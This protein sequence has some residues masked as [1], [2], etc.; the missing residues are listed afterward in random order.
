MSHRKACSGIIAAAVALGLSP[1]AGAQQATLDEVLVTARKRAEDVQDVAISMSVL[2]A[3]TLADLRI[4]DLSGIGALLP[5]VVT[6]GGG[7]AASVFSI[8]GLSTTGNNPGFETGIG[9][10]IDEVYVGK[11]FAFVTPTA[12]I[13]RIEVLRGPQGTLF[14]RNTIG[15][16][17]SIVTQSPPEEF[18]AQAKLG[19]GDYERV[20][21]SASIGGP[22]GGDSTRGHLLVHYVDQ[23]GY[24]KDFISGADYMNQEALTVRGKLA[25]EFSNSARAV[26]SV[27]YYK[28][29]NNDAMMDIRGGALAAADPFPL[30][31]RR[32]GTNFASFN[33]REAWGAS[34]RLEFDTAIGQLISITGYRR[35]EVEGLAD[36][37]FSAADISYTGRHQEHEQFSE[38]LRLQSDRDG[39]PDYI[40]GAYFYTEDLDAL[41]TAYLG[42]DVFAMFLPP[43]MLPWSESVNSAAAVDADA[44][45]LF[46]SVS[47]PLA[48]QW[49]L[50]VG[51]RYTKEDKSLAFS[52][53]LS[54]G[55]F[56]TPLMG[57]AVPIP[58]FS[59]NLDEDNFSWNATLNFQPSDDVLAYV[60]AARGFKAG[61]FNA[62]V[63]GTTPDAL[64]FRAEHVDSYELG[65]KTSWLGD[66][67]RLNMA[68]FLMDYEDKQEQTVVGAFFIVNNAARAE[69]RG[70][71]LELIGRPT[72]GLT[73]TAGLGYTDATYDS[74]PDCS[75]GG[76]DC[77][78]NRL[79]NAPE[80]SGSFAAAY[81]RPIGNDLKLW[82]SG[83]LTFRDDGFVQ[84]TND[85]AF[86]HEQRSLVGARLGV[87]ADDN[88]W[89]VTLWGSNLLDE[90]YDELAFDFLGT[91]YALLGAP[92]TWGIEFEVRTR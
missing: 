13:E 69:S 63:I 46:G 9:L 83:S 72:A 74:Y 73:L 26:F 43:F 65:L 22:L 8:R 28:D 56:M 92:R 68:A 87:G 21:G 82:L 10:Y 88:H 59:E 31:Q 61:G 33:E 80:W 51:A 18:A 12:G 15:G 3:R 76:V 77:S 19:A 58:E 20:E 78:G 2:D 89:R 62:T 75:V 54:A 11:S 44:W 35:H 5:N 41:T 36:Q 52:Q 45:A 23:E 81:E 30:S 70:F 34:A 40:L 38:E 37:D 85:P 14:G 16:A 24:L 7:Q 86:L 17:I 66:R 64:S 32:I 55:A 47:F 50:D 84:V 91:Q 67:L 71:E 48:E 57:L 49:S 27:D 39:G 6:S 4:S 25:T 53:T 1:G 90:E 79:Q 60:S 29:E 42:N